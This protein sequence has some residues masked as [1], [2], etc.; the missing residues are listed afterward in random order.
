[1]KETIRRIIPAIIA[2]IITIALSFLLTGC[3]KQPIDFKRVHIFDTS[4]YEYYEISNW[5][6]YE[7][8]GWFSAS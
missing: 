4:E 7:D 6:D 3:N 5:T 8:G 1:M 2:G